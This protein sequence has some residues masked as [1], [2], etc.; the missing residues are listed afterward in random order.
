MNLSSNLAIVTIQVETGSEAPK[1]LCNDEKMNLDN[2]Q[3]II[4]KESN[5]SLS[6]YSSTHGK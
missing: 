2:L 3:S 4:C 5:K 1:M 6:I